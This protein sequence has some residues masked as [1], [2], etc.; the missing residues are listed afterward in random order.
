MHWRG[1]FLPF[2]DV[3]WTVAWGAWRVTGAYDGYEVEISAACDDDG[4]A[5]RCP[6]PSGMTESARESY[7]GRLR[8]RLYQRRAASG[9]RVLLLDAESE[10]A[11]VEVGGS[12]WPA[13]GAPP[14][15]GVSA[16]REP[17][18]S[19]AFNLELER[20]AADQLERLQRLPFVDFP[21]L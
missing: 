9:P 21:G 4:L 7:R 20:W 17:L 8:L 13:R 10:S 5:V 15:E 18:R 11:C 12:P 1:R 19:V 14:W 16:M 6:T 3:S 2:P